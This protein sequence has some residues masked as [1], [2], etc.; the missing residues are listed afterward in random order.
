M[1]TG[2][3]DAGEEIFYILYGGFAIFI[4]ILILLE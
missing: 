2:G 4:V 3:Q 1:S